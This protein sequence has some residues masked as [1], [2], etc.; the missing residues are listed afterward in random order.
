MKVLKK[1]FIEAGKIVG[2]HGLRGEVRIDPWCDSADFLCRFRRLY[3]KN[4][5]EMK[6]KSARPHK[7][8]AIVHFDGVDKVEQAELMRGRIVYINRDDVR[9][10]EGTVFIQ[11]LI[12][13]KV[14]D[15]DKD[16]CYGEIT[17]VLKTGANDVY[18]VTDNGREYLVP[19]IPDV[20]IEKDI[21]GGYVKIRPL[22]GIFDDED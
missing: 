20:V 22:K 11:D 3:D 8:I 5:S 17:D 1:Q 10:P 2:T 16:I 12:G 19:A 6:V 18:Q 4:N 21:D 7:N 13:L 14:I 9:L 15:A